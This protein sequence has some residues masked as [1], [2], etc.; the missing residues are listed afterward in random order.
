MNKIMDNDAR[1][2]WINYKNK[3][4][5]FND[6]SNFSTEEAIDQMKRFVARIENERLNDFLFLM[7]INK[8]TF[9]KDLA[10]TSH[11]AASRIKKI[12]KRTAILGVG[13]MTIVILN[14]INHFSGLGMK[15]FKTREEALD[16]L[17][18]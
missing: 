18:L 4:I 15:A 2:T 9:S 11:W 16:Y 17:V 8:L 1:W 7:D 5:L 12:T 10:A 14:A 13:N 3:S 6:Y